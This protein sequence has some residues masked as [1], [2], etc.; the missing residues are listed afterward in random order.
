M[1]SFCPTLLPLIGI[2]GWQNW[3]NLKSF[4]GTS[5]KASV[6]EWYGDR[7]GCE[8]GG[9]EGKVD[10]TDGASRESGLVELRRN[11][12]AVLVWNGS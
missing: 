4:K 3:S 5:P 12:A 9:G 11:I 2:P 6:S 10:A 8:L 7:R 1:H